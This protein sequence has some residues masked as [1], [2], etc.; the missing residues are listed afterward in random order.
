MHREVRLLLGLQPGPRLPHLPSTKR[1]KG[2]ENP[3]VTQEG[4]I[5]II[6]VIKC[7]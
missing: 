3:L 6:E 2:A 4:L 5:F 7:P 1:A